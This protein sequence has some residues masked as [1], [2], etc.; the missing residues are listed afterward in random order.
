MKVHCLKM[1][2]HKKIA[3]L[4]LASWLLARGAMVQIGWANDIFLKGTKCRLSKLGKGVHASGNLNCNTMCI[5]N[6]NSN[7][8]YKIITVYLC[9]THEHLILK[10]LAVNLNVQFAK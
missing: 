1:Q 7:T 4:L 5:S 6:I 3:V 2:D 10:V 9:C 8:N